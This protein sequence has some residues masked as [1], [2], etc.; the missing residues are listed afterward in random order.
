MNS[1]RFSFFLLCSVALNAYATAAYSVQWDMLS[2]PVPWPTDSPW[3]TWIDSTFVLTAPWK[4]TQCFHAWFDAAAVRIPSPITFDAQSE[5]PLCAP[6][7]AS[8]G[9]AADPNDCQRFYMCVPH[10]GVWTAHHMK[11]PDCQFWDQRILTCVPVFSGTN[12]PNYTYTGPTATPTFIPEKRLITCLTFDGLKGVQGSNGISVKNTGVKIVSGPLCLHGKCAEFQD[13][14]VLEIPYF[15]NNYDHFKQFSISFFYRLVGGPIYQGLI[16]NN[17]CGLTPTGKS[18]VFLTSPNVDKLNVGLKSDTDFLAEASHLL[19]FDN[20]WHHVVMSWDGKYMRVYVD[21]NWK[22]TR[23]FAG[24]IKNSMCP[25]MIGNL[26]CGT[27]DCS[28]RGYMDE[29]CFYKSALTLAEVNAIYNN[30]G[31]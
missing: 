31:L 9:F 4:A 19:A 23:S 2:S 12:C 6:S 21:S 29:I 5:C 11:C 7:T 3:K 30:P 10:G 17:V 20:L 24:P 22:A 16:I 28:F 8:P 26:M 25:M 13:R 14:S 1:A 18:S 27:E 15:V